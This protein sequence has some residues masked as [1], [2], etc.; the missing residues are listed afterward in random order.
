MSD[1]VSLSSDQVVADHHQIEALATAMAQNAHQ[2]AGAVPED[3]P[4]PKQAKLPIPRPP[5]DHAKWEH[6]LDFAW[7][8]AVALN[9]E[10]ASAK[11]RAKHAQADYDDADST[12]RQ[13]WARYKQARDEE[14]AY[15]EAIEAGEQ[16]GLFPHG[17]ECAWEKEHPGQV[18]A[19]CSEAREALRAKEIAETLAADAAPA[20]GD[21]VV[22][23]DPGVLT[24]QEIGEPNEPEEPQS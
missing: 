23:G 20:P 18:C 6:D 22:V 9:R 4:A 7:N 17:R 2:H 19:V 1:T 14:A 8:K 13:L 15:K 16:P 24:P 21:D 5:L 10:L 12:F 3:E 11:S